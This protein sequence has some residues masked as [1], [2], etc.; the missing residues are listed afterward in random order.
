MKVARTVLTVGKSERI[1]LSEFPKKIKIISNPFKN[2]NI[3]KN[4]AY[5]GFL[6]SS[7]DNL[8][9]HLF[10]MDLVLFIILGCGFFIILVLFLYFNIDRE[11]DRTMATIGRHRRIINPQ[12]PTHR[13]DLGF[14]VR[15]A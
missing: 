13:V 9:V 2:K 8:L 1:Y 3:I 14:V 10:N 5:L 11:Y 4:S 7:D 6:S 15:Y 12:N